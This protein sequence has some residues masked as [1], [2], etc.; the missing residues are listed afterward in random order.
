MFWHLILGLL[1]D[2]RPRHGYELMTDYTARSGN[3]VSAGNFYRELAR[4]TAEGLLDTDVNPPEADARRIPYRIKDRGREVFDQ[5]LEF[6][7]MGDGDLPIWLLFA[8]RTSADVRERILE[9]HEEELWMRSK[10]LVRMRDD[11]LAGQSSDSTARYHPL[12][13]LLSRQMKRLAGELEFLKELRLEFD[14]WPRS[15]EHATEREQAADAGRP[16]T[17]PKKGSSK[18]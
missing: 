1:R 8:E 5:W 4:L 3:K 7:S 17:R 15:S 16:G 12:P 6:P 9:R 2:G 18:R 14:A 13:V 10:T 11:A